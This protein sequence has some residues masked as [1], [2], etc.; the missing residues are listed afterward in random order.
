[1]EKTV[2]AERV[3]RGFIG[4]IGFMDRLVRDGSKE[5]TSKVTYFVKEVFNHEIDLHVTNP[6]RRKA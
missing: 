2:L 3:L 5:Q 4:N 6:D 1:M